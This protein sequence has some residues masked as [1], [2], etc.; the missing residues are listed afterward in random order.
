V[1]TFAYPPRMLPLP[2][3]AT[4][5]SPG[6]GLADV[7]IGKEWLLHLVHGRSLTQAYVDIEGVGLVET[8]QPSDPRRELLERVIP[9]PFLLDPD[10]EAAIAQHRFCVC[11]PGGPLA[12]NNGS[13][14]I[15][16]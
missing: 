8:S 13:P 5:A 16:S 4:A 10:I 7:K 3:R 12:S 14:S 15:P 6:N 9:E 2:S 1:R 11:G